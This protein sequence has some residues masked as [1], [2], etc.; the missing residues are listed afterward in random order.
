MTRIQNETRL[1]CVVIGM[2]QSGD[3]LSICYG[4]TEVPTAFWRPWIP[5][6]AIC[7]P[8]LWAKYSLSVLDPNLSLSQNHPARNLNRWSNNPSITTYS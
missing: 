7:E 8:T 2:T 4:P 3:L 6:K 5:D 1:W